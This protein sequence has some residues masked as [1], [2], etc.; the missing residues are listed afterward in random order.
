MKLYEN[1]L[2]GDSFTKQSNDS[3]RDS[4]HST[5]LVQTSSSLLVGTSKDFFS[6]ISSDLNGIAASTSNMF[7]DLFGSKGS[8]KQAAQNKNQP[9]N[10]QN[11]PKE[12]KHGGV[13]GPF[14]RGPKGLVEKSPL[15]R[16]S[17]R[18][19]DEMHRKVSVDRNTTNTENQAFLKDVINS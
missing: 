14:P 4:T 7:S 8:Q 6:N 15:I 12:T 17:P 9:Q 2:Q 11:K 19:Q 16:H 1:L 13:F 5:S 10:Q 3:R 18:K